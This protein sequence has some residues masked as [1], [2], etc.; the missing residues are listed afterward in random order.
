VAIRA[1]QAR[2]PSMNGGMSLAAEDGVHVAT[3]GRGTEIPDCSRWTE[4]PPVAHSIAS[5]VE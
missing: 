4:E 1:V 5:S 3:N 2:A